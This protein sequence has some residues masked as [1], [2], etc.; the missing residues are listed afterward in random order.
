[1]SHWR[2]LI[3]DSAATTATPLHC[4][5]GAIAFIAIGAGALAAWRLRGALAAARV[6]QDRRVLILVS[7]TLQNGFPL[8]G[9][10]DAPGAPAEFAGKPGSLREPKP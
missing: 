3:E 7:G 4:T 6:E 8:R 5:L 1:M 2:R 9:N 10:L